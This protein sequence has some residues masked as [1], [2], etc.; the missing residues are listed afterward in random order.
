VCRFCGALTPVT[1]QARCLVCGG[2][3]ELLEPLA[4]A[5]GWCD[6]SN[7]RDLTDRCARC[8]GP[9]PALPGGNPGPTPPPAPR[10]LP[11]G[12]ERRLRY[13]KNVEVL[14]G[15]VFTIAFCWTILFPIIGV[16]LWLKGSRRAERTLR[17]LR[18][19][20]LTRGRITSIELDTTQSI[21]DQHPWTIAFDFDTP[22][23]PGRGTSTAWDPFNARRSRGDV[24]WVAYTSMSESEAAIWPP[25]R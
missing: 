20:Q 18:H 14:I 6:A 15:I 1:D 9:L 24:L 12:Y 13:W 16:L 22:N 4:V 3:I 25:I 2:E 7:R 21:N 10:A 17:A 19:G 8:G 5:C 23:G 11:E